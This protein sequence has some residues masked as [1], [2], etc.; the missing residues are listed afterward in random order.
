MNLYAFNKNSF[1]VKF[2]KWATGINP[3]Q[4]YKTM[5]PYFWSYVLLIIFIIPVAIF[6]GMIDI[7]KYINKKYFTVWIENSRRKTADKYAKKLHVTTDLSKIYIMYMKNDFNYYRV[8]SSIEWNFGIV[9]RENIDKLINDSKM[10]HF[11]K[12]ET[13]NIKKA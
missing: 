7:I 6:S 1:H 3:T 13:K 12:K 2:F 10:H 5:C 11:L 4:R 9:A 8:M